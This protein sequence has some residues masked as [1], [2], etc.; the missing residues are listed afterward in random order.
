MGSKYIV[1]EEIPI[2]RERM[3]RGEDV[4]FYALLVKSTSGADVSE[5]DNPA[6]LRKRHRVQVLGPAPFLVSQTRRHEALKTI[7]ARV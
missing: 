1:D 3:R 6:W 4:K 7:L 2:I 5:A